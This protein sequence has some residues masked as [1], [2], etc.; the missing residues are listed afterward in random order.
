MKKIFVLFP[1]LF[2]GSWL[3]AQYAISLQ[4]IGAS[5]LDASAGNLYV[6]STLGELAIPTIFNNT[7]TLSQGFHQD[8]KILIPV[9][10][11]TLAA[12]NGYRL[13][14]NP[15]EGRFQ[16]LGEAPFSSAIQYRLTDVSGR[17]L[18]QTA[19][20]QGENAQSFDLSAQSSGIYYLT[21]LGPDAQLTFPIIKL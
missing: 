4:V 20:N 19:L 2:F 16:L 1:L 18:D 21:L 13:F 3:I 11:R 17:L 15:T 6:N 7:I 9:S 8:A 12:L 10:T 14:P 5:G